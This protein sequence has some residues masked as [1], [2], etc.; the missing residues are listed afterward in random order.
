MITEEVI[1]GNNA[2]IDNALYSNVKGITE[3]T[4][5]KRDMIDLFIL[6][7]IFVSLY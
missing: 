4:H 3:I 6:I 5:I 7:N 1:D 2:N